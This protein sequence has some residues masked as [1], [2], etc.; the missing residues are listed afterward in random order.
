LRP[1][2]NPR[3]RLVPLPAA[4]PPLRFHVLGGIALAGAVD[5][6]AADRL[7][8]QPKAVA[9]LVY[10]AL[11][12]AGRPARYQRRD[13]LVGL[14]WPELDQTH[15][16]GALRKAVHAARAVL[17]ADTV[18]SRGDEELAL[19]DGALWCDAAAFGQA[20]EAG[21][22]AQ[23]LELYAGDLLPASTW[24]SA[25]SSGAGSTTR[26][27]SCASA[28]PAPRG[29]SRAL[30]HAEQLT[31]AGRWA[32]RAVRYAWDDERALRRA[33]TLLDRLGD[34]AG[35]LRLYDEFA[36]RLRAE[37]EAEPSRETLAMAAALRPGRRCPSRRRAAAWR[38]RRDRAPGARRAASSR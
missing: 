9:L 38:A 16:R 24:P 29:R 27:R 1:F 25:R 33:I 34:R 36:R 23:A 11:A 28:P 4:T 31:E 6:A 5:P 10:L 14:L 20:E 26:A 35:A 13:R 7:L 37:Y 2:A 3:P 15:A 30:A 12:A 19:A 17:G 8:A 18:L 21:R 32:R 22:L